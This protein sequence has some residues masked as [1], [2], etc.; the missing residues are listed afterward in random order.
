MEYSLVI[1]NFLEEISGLS[2]SIVFLYFCIDRR[3]RL[4]YL[5][6]LFFG[7]LYSDEYIFH[8][9]PLP[10][11]SL[12]FLAICKASSDNQFACLHFFFLG[13][14]LGHCLLYSVM[15]LHP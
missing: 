1:T 4:S 12:L 10:I 15:N 13:D 7:A 14:G 6:L 2:H 11:T 9:S 8:F 5:S 3:G